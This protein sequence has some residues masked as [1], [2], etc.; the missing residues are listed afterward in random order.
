M[1][2]FS[3]HFLTFLISLERIRDLKICNRKISCETRFRSK[4]VLSAIL[5]CALLWFAFWT[6]CGS[7][8]QYLEGPLGVTKTCP[9]IML[10]VQCVAACKQKTLQEKKSE[11]GSS[12][13]A[14]SERSGYTNAPPPW[15]RTYAHTHTDT[16]TYTH[17]HPRGLASRL[18]AKKQ[19]KK[20]I[21]K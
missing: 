18:P 11:R 8:L 14:S 1:K 3:W 10:V 7:W 19:N 2:C 13:R 17:A 21:R 15:G 6:V 5:Y 20:Q 12:G 9:T 16:H 4:V